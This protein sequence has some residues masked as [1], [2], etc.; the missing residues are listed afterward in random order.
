MPQAQNKTQPTSQNVQAFLDAIED[1]QQRRDSQE[2]CRM[3]NEISGQPATMW[4]PSIIG[5]GQYH[6]EYA[7]GREGDSGAIGFSP[8]KGNTTIY[9]VDGISKYENLLQKLGPHKTAKVCLYIKRLSDVN[10]GVLRQIIEESYQ[11][12]MTRKNDMHRAE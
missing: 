8:R 10:M 3:M 7:S 12:V 6:Y 4:G 5:F 11:Y 1:E 2:I 9:I